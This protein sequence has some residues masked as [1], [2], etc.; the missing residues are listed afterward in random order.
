M[1]IGSWVLILKSGTRGRDVFMWKERHELTVE[2]LSFLTRL[3]TFG[4]SLFR[5]ILNF[6]NV[7]PKIRDGIIKINQSSIF[8]LL[9]I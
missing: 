2:Q 9:F 1:E 8:G 6:R 5:H 4:R 7:G 3:K